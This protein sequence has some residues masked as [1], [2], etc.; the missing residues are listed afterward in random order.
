MIVYEINS[1][2]VTTQL[3]TLDNEVDVGDPGLV[4]GL[5]GAGVRPLIS[6]LHLVDVDGK[7]TV[8]AVD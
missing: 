8:V 5:E 7:I 3:L 1:F 6:H 2:K 4:I